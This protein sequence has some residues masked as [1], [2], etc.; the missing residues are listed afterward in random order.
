MT[1]RGIVQDGIVILE[2]A[3]GLRNGESVAVVP[4]RKGGASR[5]RRGS[6]LPR[7][8]RAKARRGVVRSGSLDPLPGFG[9]WKNRSDWKGKTTLQIAAGLRRKAMGRRR[10]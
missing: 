4:S 10:V 2:S 6:A 9:M 7:K 3:T 8:G 5:Q 1:Y